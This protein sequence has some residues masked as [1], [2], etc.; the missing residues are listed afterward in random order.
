AYQAAQATWDT[1]WNDLTTALSQF[2]ASTDTS[3]Q[4]YQAGGERQHRSLGLRP[5]A[6]TCSWEPCSRSTCPTWPPVRLN[7][8]PTPPTWPLPPPAAS[9]ASTSAGAAAGGGPLV[10]ALARLAGDTTSR[11]G[12]AGS[13]VAS[14][15]STLTANA[16]QYTA[17][18]ASASA[19]FGA[20]SPGHAATFTG[21]G[22]DR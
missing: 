15:G 21:Y 2:Q 13:D 12:T 10:A 11:G 4:T 18:D 16:A 1:A 22:V 3:N 5:G 14:G 17:D 19:T 7:S 20:W 9:A 8:P 6:E